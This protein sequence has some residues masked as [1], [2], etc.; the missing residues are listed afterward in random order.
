L[1]DVLDRDRHIARRYWMAN[2]MLG[3]LSA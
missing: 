3:R 2:R 1:P